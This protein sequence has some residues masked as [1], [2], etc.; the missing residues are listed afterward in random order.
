MSAEAGDRACL[1]SRA[2][3]VEQIGIHTARLRFGFGDGPRVAKS[4]KAM[5]MVCMP[6]FWLACMMPGI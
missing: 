4:I 2:C 5:S 6:S 3:R 1:V